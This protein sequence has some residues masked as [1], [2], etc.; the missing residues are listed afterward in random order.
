[1]E[2]KEL[3]RER[4]GHMAKIRLGGLMLYI[5]AVATVLNIVL[6]YI[7]FRVF[8]PCGLKTT[9]YWFVDH[10]ADIHLPI[11]AGI[12][13]SVVIAGA[14]ALIGYF[15]REKRNYVCYAV[16]L[17]VYLLDFTRFFAPGALLEQM[18]QTA[19]NP[20]LLY[21][22]GLTLMF[23]LYAAILLFIG[24]R[25]FRKVG[26]VDKRVKEEGLTPIPDNDDPTKGMTAAQKREYTKQTRKNS[27]IPFRRNDT[28]EQTVLSIDPNAAWPEPEKKPKKAKNERIARE[29]A[30]EQKSAETEEKEPEE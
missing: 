26:A 16:G 8:V 7:N 30:E 22:H 5:C 10:V 11:W 27:L 19:A 6:T 25:A 17:I 15:A 20:I 23:D 3:R 29:D 2:S 13:L 4:Y 9:Q 14:V 18:A 24:F 28:E 12:V 21:D 1:M